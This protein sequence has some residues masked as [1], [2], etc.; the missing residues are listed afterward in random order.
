MKKL[1]I[2]TIVA[3]AMLSAISIILSRFCVIW[4]TNSIRISFGNIPI[5]LAGILF[6]PLAGG[7][8]GAAS[9][10]LGAAFLSGLGWY[11][12]ITISP[13]LMGVIPGLLHM[14]VVRKLSWVRMACVV[15]PADII[16]AMG[17]STFCLYTLYGTPISVLLTV[18]IPLYLAIAFLETSILFMLCKSNIFVKTAVWPKNTAQ[19]AID[20]TA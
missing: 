17:W 4:I 16:A 12:P 8:V 10:I 6:G 5:I 20:L 19:G 13:I 1:S 15:L 3:L 7:L 18:R 11:P 2:K 9:D 14:L